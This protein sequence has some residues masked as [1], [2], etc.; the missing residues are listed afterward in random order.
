MGGTALYPAVAPMQIPALA[1]LAAALLQAPA[2]RA[3]LLAGMGFGAAFAAIILVQLSLPAATRLSLFLGITIWWALLGWGLA[4][5]LRLRTAAGAWAAAGWVVLG[6][7][8]QSAAL[9][10]FGTAQ[11]FASAW[12][13]YPGTAP[14]L[15]AGGTLL[16]TFL[17]CALSF[18]LAVILGGA[19]APARPWLLGG[20]ASTLLIWGAA[21]LSPVEM[22]AAKPFRIAVV[23]A[24]GADGPAFGAPTYWQRYG[25][26]VEAASAKGASL[27]V[28]PELA[29]TLLPSERDSALAFLAQQAQRLGLTMAIGWG[30]ISPSRNRAALLNTAEAP[31]SPIYDKTHWVADVERYDHGG[32]GQP[33]LSTSV[34]RLKVGV[35]ICQDDNFINVAQG[36]ARAG[37]Q[38]VAVPTMD[39]ATVEKLHLT[40]ARNRS[41]EFGFVLARGALGGISALVDTR[42]QV[43][44]ARNHLT[45]GLGMAMGDVTLPPAR[46]TWYARGGEWPALVLATLALLPGAAALLRRHPPASAS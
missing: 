36:L 12:V 30:E 1:L 5:L 31:V 24:D 16:L 28:L 21:Q 13:E 15:Q 23:G 4:R 14:L 9:P 37:A 11:R 2:S 19:A 43:V 46:L 44:A 25:P 10:F 33:V 42:G 35:M 39:W 3:N 22:A 29:M 7:W 26:L 34:G 18:S 32:H 45:T 41:R 8:A 6:E 38:V 40:N 20:L 17:L 27:V